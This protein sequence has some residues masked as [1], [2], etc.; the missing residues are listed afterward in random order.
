MKNE[1]YVITVANQIFS[2]ETVL[3]LGSRIR[4]KD[5]RIHIISSGKKWCV[6]KA[7]ATRAIKIEKH[8]EEAYYYARKLSDNIVVHN[9]DGS[10]CFH[11]VKNGS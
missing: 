7:G 4:K 6:K 11:Y 10:I 2:Y 3:L 1:P 5:V 9:K 8:R